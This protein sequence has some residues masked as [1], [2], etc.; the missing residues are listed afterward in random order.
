MNTLIFGD[1]E[2]TK[3]KFYDNKE[4]VSLNLVDINK[5]VVIYG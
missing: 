1:T 3:K 5:I 2:V 4:T